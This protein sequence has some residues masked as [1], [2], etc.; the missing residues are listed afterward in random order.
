MYIIMIIDFFFFL[1][2]LGR[3]DACLHDMDGIIVVPIMNANQC[4]HIEIKQK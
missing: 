3:A 1:V 2:F 4:C